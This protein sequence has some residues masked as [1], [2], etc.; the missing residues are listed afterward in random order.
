MRISIS[1]LLIFISSHYISQKGKI[2]GYTLDTK[3]EIIPNVYI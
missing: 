2:S 3:N 1:I